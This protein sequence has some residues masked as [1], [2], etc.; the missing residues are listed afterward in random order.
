M[1]E[2][3][4]FFSHILFIYYCQVLMKLKESDHSHHTIIILFF[5]LIVHRHVNLYGI[6]IAVVDDHDQ[7]IS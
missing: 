3:L 4:T 7:I 2:K 6:I 1:K 5:L